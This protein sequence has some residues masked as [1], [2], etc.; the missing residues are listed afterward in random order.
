MNQK[1]KEHLPQLT[2]QNLG[3]LD[4]GSVAR[5]FGDAVEQILANISKFPCRDGNKVETRSLEL[6][7]FFTPELRLDKRGI[8]SA[9]GNQMEVDVPELSG[10]SVRVKIKSALPDAE[11]A[12]VK[13]AC[14]IIN[15][16]IADMRFNPNNN[17]APDQL[18][19]DLDRD[20][21]SYRELA[22]SR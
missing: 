17:K 15:G 4:R 7:V 11:T 14:D 22:G 19:F 6:K 21:E 13:M 18:E 9:N 3:Q 16:R 12:D 1:L 5:R 10:V 2:I 8:E 20:E